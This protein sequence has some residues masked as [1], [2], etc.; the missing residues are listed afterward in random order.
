PI[1]VSVTGPPGLS[2][3]VMIKPGQT[4]SALVVNAKPD[5]PKGPYLTTI[6]GKAKVDGKE[7][8]QVASAR[9]GLSQ[10]LAGLP[11]PPLNLNTQVALGVKDKAPFTVA[12]T[13]NTPEGV[14]GIPATLKIAVTREAGFAEEVSINPP[15]NL[16]PNVAAP[17]IGNIAKDKNEVSFN[18][19]INGKV[20]MGEYALLFSAKSKLKEGE[21]SAAAMPL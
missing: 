2:G 3:T 18:L 19:D 5:M 10:E 13:M 8:T 9:V 1:D 4:A 11:Y 7:M 15:A 17:K 14:P 16:P 20:P 12:V 6:V 21:V